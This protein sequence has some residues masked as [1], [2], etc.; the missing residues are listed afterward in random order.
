[1]KLKKNPWVVPLPAS[2]FKHV[3]E[4]TRPATQC[5]N[6]E[7][8][9]N[10]DPNN[11]L[12]QDDRRPPDYT[13]PSPVSTQEDKKVVLAIAVSDIVVDEHVQGRRRGPPADHEIRLLLAGVVVI[14]PNVPE[15]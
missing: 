1:M 8:T 9:M 6:E 7:H 5:E 14:D 12:S 11:S 15:V 13:G 3:R 2:P 4:A 10:L